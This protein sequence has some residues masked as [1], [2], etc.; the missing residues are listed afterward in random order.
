MAGVSSTVRYELSDAEF[1]QLQLQDP[2]KVRLEGLASIVAPVRLRVL[3]CYCVVSCSGRSRRVNCLIAHCFF[4]PCSSIPFHLPS[5]AAARR[6]FIM[7][8][9]YLAV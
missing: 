6:F 4:S 2:F 1:D 8:R 3:V 5:T 7:L 9:V